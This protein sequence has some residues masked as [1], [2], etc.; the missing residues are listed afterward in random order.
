MDLQ[1]IDSASNYGERRR[2]SMQD[3]SSM[4]QKLTAYIDG[5]ALDSGLCSHVKLVLA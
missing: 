1:S 5:L 4:Y 2:L 3:Q